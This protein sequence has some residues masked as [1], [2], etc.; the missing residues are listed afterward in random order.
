MATDFNPSTI[1]NIP[2]IGSLAVQRNSMTPF[3]ALYCVTRQTAKSTPRAD[4]LE[5]GRLER[6]DVAISIS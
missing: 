2:F 3:D 5:H 4:G 6:G 1:N